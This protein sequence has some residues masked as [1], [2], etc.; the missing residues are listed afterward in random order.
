MTKNTLHAVVVCRPNG[1]WEAILLDVGVAVA[2]DNKEELLKELAYALDL[3][4]LIAEDHK[5]EPFVDQIGIHDFDEADFDMWSGIPVDN[6]TI[7]ALAKALGWT[8]PDLSRK[9]II[10]STSRQIYL[11]KLNKYYLDNYNRL[12]S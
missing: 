7:T 8:E 3:E 5:K 4:R 11:D 10:M 12:G 9:L 6:K 1:L 2:G